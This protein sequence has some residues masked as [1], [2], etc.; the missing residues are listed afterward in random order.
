MFTVEPT[1]VAMRGAGAALLL[2]S[3]DLLEATRAANPSP[4]MIALAPTVML[5]ERRYHLQCETRS[6]HTRG[7]EESVG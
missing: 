6:I 3:G 4:M 2:H 1:G 7:D 5:A